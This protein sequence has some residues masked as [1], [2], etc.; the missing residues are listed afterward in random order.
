MTTTKRTDRD[1]VLRAFTFFQDAANGVGLQ[2]DRI[3]ENPL[4]MQKL[5]HICGLIGRR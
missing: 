1:I 4:L 3:Q 5:F 2:M